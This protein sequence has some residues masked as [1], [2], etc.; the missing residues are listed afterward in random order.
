MSGSNLFG[1]AVELNF[2]VAPVKKPGPAKLLRAARN[3]VLLTPTDLEGLL[4][5]DH[6]ARGMWELVGKLDLSRFLAAIAS[7]EADS[8]RPAIDPRILATLWLY[9]TS[10]GVTSARELASLCQRHDAYRWICGGVPVCP[11]TLSDFRVDH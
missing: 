10:E 11:H 2:V 6:I 5:E 7:R 8:G 4:P 3:Q 9:A 1:E